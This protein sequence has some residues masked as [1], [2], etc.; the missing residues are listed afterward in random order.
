MSTEI[1]SVI[2][3]FTVA[4]SLNAFTRIKICRGIKV[5]PDTNAA[6]F[7]HKYGKDYTNGENSKIYVI[8]VIY[9]FLSF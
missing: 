4:Q 5:L 2:L 6:L 8:T 1:S 9:F 7:I 3:V